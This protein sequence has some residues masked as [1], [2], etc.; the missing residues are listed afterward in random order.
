V[1][2][3][4]ALLADPKCVKASDKEALSTLLD[5][6]GV[7]SATDLEKLLKADNWELHLEPVIACLNRWATDGASIG[8]QPA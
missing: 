5:D 2:A 1:G 6:L 8:P 4:W 3:A 7:E